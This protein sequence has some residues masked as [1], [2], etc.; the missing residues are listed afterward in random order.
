MTEKRWVKVGQGNFLKW[1]ESG[2]AIEGIWRGQHDGRF[3]PLG[4]LDTAQGRV[5]FPLHTALLQRVENL[6]VGAEVRIEY[7]GKQQTKDGQRTFKAFD[8]Y[9]ADPQKDLIEP[10]EGEP[11]EGVPF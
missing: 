10:E 3:G 1:T 6:Q 9:V 7:Q 5:S 4:L 11:E 8:V 2:Q